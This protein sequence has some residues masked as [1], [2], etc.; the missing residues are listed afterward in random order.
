MACSKPIVCHVGNSSDT[1]SADETYVFVHKKKPDQFFIDLTKDGPDCK[2][3][4]TGHSADKNCLFTSSMTV[5]ENNGHGGTDNDEVQIIKCVPGD[6][7][8]GEKPLQ[9]KVVD[10]EQF[11]KWENVELSS[12]QMNPVPHVVQQKE[13][14]NPL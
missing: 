3:L 6:A 2:R 5:P 8:E 10:S 7:A 1:D 11:E 4:K 14:N 12:C 13:W 9:C